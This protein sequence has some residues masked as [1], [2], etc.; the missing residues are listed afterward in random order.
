MLK[1]LFR[2]AMIY[3]VT[4]RCYDC[5]CNA[6]NAGFHLIC[7]H[8]HSMRIN[9]LLSNQLTRAG[10]QKKSFKADANSAQYNRGWS[11]IVSRSEVIKNCKEHA[12]I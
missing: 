2:D 4:N 10:K 7:L 1:S 11:T 12:V 5:R 3:R 9:H 6:M 8:M